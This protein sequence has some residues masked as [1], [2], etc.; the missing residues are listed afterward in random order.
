[1]TAPTAKT[2]TGEEIEKLVKRLRLRADDLHRD[3]S[4]RDCYTHGDEMLDRAAADALESAALGTADTA[5]REQSVVPVEEPTEEMLRAGHAAMFVDV[6]YS[7]AA[8]IVRRGYKAMLTASPTPAKGRDAE[9][10]ERYRWL[11]AN[12]G[13]SVSFAKPVRFVTPPG[14]SLRGVSG[15]SE[16]EVRHVAA[17]E[18]DAAIDAALAASKEKA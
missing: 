9:E 6:K 8:D 1:M 10:A 4:G 17:L 5:Q 13:A 2:L 14:L 18:L 15:G 3:P 11:R 16:I 7:R 12:S